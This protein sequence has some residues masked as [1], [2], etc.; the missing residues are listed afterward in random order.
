VHLHY[1][2]RSGRTARAGNKGVSL[3][4]STKG[5]VKKIR[6]LEQRLKIAFEKDV[7]P[8]ITSIRSNKLEQWANSIL[9]MDVSKNIAKEDW[10]KV[11]EVFVDLDKDALLQK[12]I[13]AELQTLSGSSES[14]DL[15][16][17]D[18]RGDRPKGDPNVHRF[19]INLGEMDEMDEDG[20]VGLITETT[21]INK[22]SISDVTVLN[23]CSYYTI[24][25]DQSSKIE[26]ALNGIELNGR[27]VRTNRDDDS[28]PRGQKKGRGDR[29]GGRSGGGSYGRSGGG[30]S[31]DRRRSGGGSSG[32]NSTGG[33]GARKGRRRY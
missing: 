26:G 21:G 14:K 24:N 22:N 27:E 5:D 23:K 9:K 6:F 12:L 32:R 13:S 17:L 33:G 25:K 11:Q 31:S 28:Q 19:Y 4:L 7:V 18:A 10:E 20:L 15:N 3:T 29:R 1:T 8:S 2:H 16:V 30:R